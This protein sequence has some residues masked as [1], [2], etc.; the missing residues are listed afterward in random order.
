[1]SSVSVFAGHF[2]WRLASRVTL[3]LLALTTL[4]NAQ[5]QRRE[6]GYVSVG[7]GWSS[8]R[9]D[10][11][12][13]LSCA[14]VAVGGRLVGGLVFARG[15]TA[16]ALLIDFGRARTRRQDG[17][18]T[19]HQLMVGLGS[20]V[21]V[22]LGGGLLASLR[23]GLALNRVDRTFTRPGGSSERIGNT[24]YVDGYGGLSVLFRVTRDLAVEIG[25]DATG[26]ED[27]VSRDSAAMG[28]V[29]LSLRF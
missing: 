19:V 16:E 25:F 11:T 18:V 20:A 17:D 10:C 23:G 3:A 22:E 15:F 28:F 6:V 27:Q 24:G 21:Q 5:A 29:G 2:P 4:S 13:A 8:M 14:Q 26:I 1:M 7:G 9:T 12:F